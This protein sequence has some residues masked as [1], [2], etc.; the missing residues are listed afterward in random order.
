L[1][2]LVIFGMMEE[3]CSERGHRLGGKGRIAREKPN[4]L[5][6]WARRKDVPDGVHRD[7]QACG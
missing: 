1:F 7:T 6:S 2:N 5:S 4:I 3:R